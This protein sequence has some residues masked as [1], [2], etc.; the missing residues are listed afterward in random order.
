MLKKFPQESKNEEWKAWRERLQFF[1]VYKYHYTL[2]FGFYLWRRYDHNAQSF[3]LVL[4]SGFTPDDAEGTLC[5]AGN[6]MLIW[7]ME[8]KLPSHCR[9]SLAS[10]FKRLLSVIMESEKKFNI[11]LI[12]TQEKIFTQKKGEKVSNWQND[13]DMYLFSLNW[14]MGK[15][16]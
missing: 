16:F 7:N 8:G 5:G 14:R 6:Q 2:S 15:K 12:F 1:E 4:C 11:E 9:F 3:L 13:S 10:N